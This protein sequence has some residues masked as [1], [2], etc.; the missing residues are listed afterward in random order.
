VL[1]SDESNYEVLNRKNRKY[2][3]HKRRFR[4]DRARF[5]RSQQHAHRYSW[6]GVQS[7]V[8]CHDLGPVVFL[9]GRLDSIKYI[10]I[11]DTH[12]STV[13]RK[14][15]YG[16]IRKILYQHDNAGPHVSVLSKE[17][18]EK[19]DYIALL[20]DEQPGSEYY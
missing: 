20:A 16:Q 17:Y 6:I 7:Y 1:F 8:T 3:I 14:F 10:D 4:N 18:L 15:A 12:S 5:D 9:D 13:L 19:K 11:V 2:P